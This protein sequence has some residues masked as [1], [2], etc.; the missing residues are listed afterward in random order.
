M[1]TNFA[2][3]LWNFKSV[4]QTATKFSAMGLTGSHE[5]SQFSAKIIVYL[6]KK[7]IEH[8]K[9]ITVGKAIFQL[10]VENFA[11]F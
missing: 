4:S 3:R 8:L 10:L 7:K 6:W 5:I 1:H 2:D 9:I 11:D